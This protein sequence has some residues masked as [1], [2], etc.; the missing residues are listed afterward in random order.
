MPSLML[1]RVLLPPKLLPSLAQ[2]LQNLLVA[3]IAPD[4]NEQPEMNHSLHDFFFHI[5]YT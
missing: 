5:V 3:E 1:H 4:Q 2:N